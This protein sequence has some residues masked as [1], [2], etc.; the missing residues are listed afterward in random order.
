MRALEL[1]ASNVHA[2]SLSGS[3]EAADAQSCWGTP[4]VGREID[5]PIST[6]YLR[7]GLMFLLVSAERVAVLRAW[8]VPELAD[9]IM[10]T[11]AMS[12]AMAQ[13]TFPR[14]VLPRVALTVQGLMPTTGYSPSGS[15]CEFERQLQRSRA[16]FLKERVEAT[17]ALVE[18]RGRLEKA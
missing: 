18:H 15:E 7:P 12:V 1:S 3:S 8:A 4:S 16:A 14:T 13:R 5:G 2:N 10:E 11:M 9:E 17:E 6:E